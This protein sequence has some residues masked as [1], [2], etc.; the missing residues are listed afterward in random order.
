MNKQPDGTM[1][2]LEKYG[3]PLTRENYLRLAFNGNPPP[4]PLDGEVEEMLPEELQLITLIEVWH[5]ELTAEL[6][7]L[8]A[9]SKKR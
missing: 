7:E 5:A 6:A 3:I 9:K 8:M 4:E 2:L 1:R